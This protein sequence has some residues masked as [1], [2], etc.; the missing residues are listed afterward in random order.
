RRLRGS[1]V[2]RATTAA[3]RLRATP[4]EVSSATASAA[5]ATSAGS[6]SLPGPRTSVISP[7]GGSANCSASPRALPRTTCS[8]R[9]VSSRQTASRRSGPTAASKRTRAGGARAPF[10]GLRSRRQLRG[11][12]SLVVLVVGTQARPDPVA[13]KQAPCVTR[14]F[15]EDE[16][17]LGQL[18]Q[19]AQRDVFEISDR[20]R[21]DREHQP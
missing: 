1:P 9:F 6:R 4:A 17:G 7:F 15:T 16:L 19:H 14:V 18:T 11:P 13:F 8:C 10:A 3:A 20:R 5:A 2:R 12:R 21:A